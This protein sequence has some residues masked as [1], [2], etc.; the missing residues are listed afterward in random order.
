MNDKHLEAEL[1]EQKQL[2][3]NLV[4][5]A[6]AVTELPTM[7]ATLQNVLD[8]ATALTQAEHS[9]LLVLDQGGAVAHSILAGGSPPALKQRLR[10][11]TLVMDGG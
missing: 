4:T 6:R 1:R 9:S 8:V 11:A 5:V 7:E 2:F 10:I 3:E